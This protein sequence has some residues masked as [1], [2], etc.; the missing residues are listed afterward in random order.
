VDQFTNSSS[1]QRTDQYGGSIENRTR[2]ALE[3]VD[4][5]A[6][7]IGEDKTALRLSPFSDYQDATDDT[8]VATWSHITATLE[9]THPHLAYLHFIEPRVSL[10]VDG[11]AGQES[12]ESL[13]PILAHWSGPVISSG[14]YTYDIKTAYA[15]AEKGPNKLV[16]FG[17]AFIANPD[18][19][20]RVRNHWKLNPYNRAT[21]YTPGPEGYIDYPYYKEDK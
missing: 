7:A 17:R 12:G 2:F 10:E 1:N 13:D 8:P 3:I 16:A 14:N 11:P 6:Q 4:A 19:V 21:F 5:I 15:Y 18:L 9:K 20:E